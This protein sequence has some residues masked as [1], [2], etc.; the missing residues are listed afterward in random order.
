VI[1]VVVLNWKNAEDTIE[2]LTSV[3]RVKVPEGET[4]KILC[5]DNDS[6]DG[7]V[8]RIRSAAPYA[9]ILET[10][11]N[12]GY[13]GGNNFGIKYALEHGAEYL[14]ILNNDTTV[15]E[16]ALVGLIE[17]FMEN[18]ELGATGSLVMYY[19]DK[20]TVW[21]AGGK[22]NRFTGG[23]SHFLE[24]K[25]YDVSMDGAV[26][27]KKHDFL[28]GC[29]FMVPK[30]T[31][32]ATGLL[33]EGL[34]LLFEEMDFFCRMKKSGLSWVMSPESVIYHKVS[35]SP[36]L[37]P[38]RLYYFTRN[39]IVISKTFFSFYLP[40]VLLFSIKWPLMSTLIKDNKNLKYVGKAYIDAFKGI[41]GPYVEK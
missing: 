28:S 18:Q 37:N 24:N 31:I 2:C 33:N 14:W 25:K 26:K 22:Y 20:N 9:Q 35:R 4:L 40:F 7:S 38:M 19:D 29:S 13:A 10:G 16:N 8:E 3:N 39:M 17:P 30:K 34:Y 11:G 12:L 23:T 32:E 6:N 15:E 5:V 27:Q 36:I 1:Y 21:F 41:G